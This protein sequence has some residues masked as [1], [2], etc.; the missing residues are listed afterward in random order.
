[1]TCET[2]TCECKG[3]KTAT[4]CDACCSPSQRNRYYRGKAMTVANYQL[5][6]KYL[7]GRRRLLNRMVTGWGIVK[8]FDVT[9]D[10]EGASLTVHPGVAIDPAGRELVGCDEVVFESADD[11]VWLERGK[12]G[13]KPGEPGPSGRYLLC[14]FYAERLVQ[15]TRVSDGCGDAV[16]EADQICET[17][18]FGLRPADGDH[19]YDQ[20]CADL[21]APEP[22]P[23]KPTSPT[24][25][26]DGGESNESGEAAQTATDGSGKGVAAKPDSP[27]DD[28][29]E[30]HVADLSRR[31][32]TGLCICGD[33]DPCTCG[34]AMTRICDLLVDL[35]ACVPLAYVTVERDDCRLALSAPERVIGACELT[36]ICDVGWA[37]WHR[38]REVEIGRTPF[39]DMFVGPQADDPRQASEE[40]A[41]TGVQ[42]VDSQ[43]WICFTGPVQTASLSPD[44]VT[45]SLAT[46]ESD[47]VYWHDAELKV[48]A[49]W[50]APT[51]DGD[52]PGTTRGFRLLFP[53]AFWNGE[54]RQGMPS[55]L[56]SP[57]RVRLTIDGNA[58]IDWQ[59]LPID[60]DSIAY[61]LPSGNGVPGGT[62]VSTWRVRARGPQIPGHD[63][64]TTA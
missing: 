29:P 25:G 55:R 61:R 63:P 58:I 11:L 51:S 56:N 57:T 1:M 19:P 9:V 21:R 52:P 30:P 20:P 22:D 33:F 49:I 37:N 6:Q 24:K 16:C 4:G 35:D 8:G 64:I 36:R 32:I 38:G 62:F 31:G 3:P 44:V 34:K 23:V 12:C 5:E 26:S 43:F 41:E 54:I 53:A 13:A 15:H 46:A 18:V 28:R 14:A 39:F 7:I 27:G 50:T 45:M 17:V 48:E 10:G 47:E 40:V 60:A 2:T 59:G 42:T